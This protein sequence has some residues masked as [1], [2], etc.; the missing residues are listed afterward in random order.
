MCLSS[1]INESNGI[2]ALHE[3]TLNRILSQMD[4]H[5]IAIITAYRKEFKNA[6]YNTFDDR[7][8]ELQ[9]MDIEMGI[10]DPEDKTP[11]TY[12][13]KEKIRRNHELK[14]CLLSL[15]Y[16]IIKIHGNYI[17]NFGTVDAIELGEESFF[18][19]NLKDLPDF[20][21]NLFNLSEYY[22]Q[23]C[24][25]YKPR[26]SAVAFNIGT[27]NNEYPGYGKEDNLGILHINIE[28]EFL[29]RLGNASFSFTNEDPTKH[30]TKKYDF[31][32]RKNDRM[33]LKE[34]L[35]VDLYENYSRGSRMS[36]KSIYNKYLIHNR[37]T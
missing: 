32:T 31:H 14:A 19:I 11:Y 16:G 21:K 5:D 15:N 34:A 23:D 35:N 30:S 17:E 6:T 1:I 24:F 28:S 9:D 7:P 27:N 8:K 36:I 4:L 37:K 22:N 13:T 20:K 26:E 2:N 25:L 3:S 33:L 18:V 29:S 12:T 10:T